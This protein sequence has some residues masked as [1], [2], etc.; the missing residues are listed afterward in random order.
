MRTR[1]KVALFSI[2]VML[3]CSIVLGTSYSIWTTSVQQEGENV[4]N[5]GCF[6]ITYTDTG[7]ENAGAINLANEY[8]ITDSVGLSKQPYKFTIKNECSVAASYNVNLETLNGSTM[9]T[10]Y[11][12]VLFDDGTPAL[13]SSNTFE[14][15][16]PYLTADS[17]SAIKLVSGY[18]ADGQS[19]TYSLRLWIDYSAETTSTNVMGETYLGKVV[20]YSQ[21]TKTVNPGI[22]Y[23]GDGMSFTQFLTDNNVETPDGVDPS[24]YVRFNNE[25]W[26]VA[27]VFPSYG[28]LL[29]KDKPIEGYTF[30]YEN[31]STYTTSPFIKVE[32]NDGTPTTVNYYD[33]LTTEAKNMILPIDYAFGG[34]S[35]N[36]LTVSEVYNATINESKNLY[37]GLGSVANYIYTNSDESCELYNFATDLNTRKCTNTS[38]IFGNDYIY[39]ATSGPNGLYIVSK[40]GIKEITTETNVKILPSVAIGTE[41]LVKGGEGTRSNPYIIEK[42]SA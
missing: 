42:P 30:D 9:N 8:P 25:L 1:Y 6:Q 22:E 34:V 35:S 23:D 33:T 36:N 15:V 29:V 3:I 2:T 12:K 28:M 32:D 13:Y 14:E 18:L 17:M 7:F 27:N 10:N 4:V 39:T 40:K 26:R 11:L 21:A 20:V 38:Y 41:V 16:T 31:L 5:V 37:V 19:V 24:N